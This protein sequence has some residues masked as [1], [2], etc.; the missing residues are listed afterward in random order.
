[1]ILK[2]Q[3]EKKVY[4]DGNETEQRMLQIAEKYPEDESQ[5]YIA[6]NSEYT[7]NNTFSSVRQNILN[8]YPFKKDADILEV[9]QEWALLQEC[10]VI[11]QKMLRR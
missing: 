1:M 7:V 8:W 3:K 2:D 5:D 11:E 4:S 9:V 10:Y 6:N